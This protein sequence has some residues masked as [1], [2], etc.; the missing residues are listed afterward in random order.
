NWLLFDFGRRDAVGDAARAR[1][2]AAN[3]GFN[4]AHQRVVFNVT[5][6][7]YALIDSRQRIAVAAAEVAAAKAVE[8]AVVDRNAHGLATNVE[9]LQ[10]RRQALESAFGYESSLSHESDALVTLAEAVG[11]LP[12]TKFGIAEPADDV[13]SG[14]MEDTVDQAID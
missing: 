11:I 7:Y 8:D 10:A 9:L 12:T 1:A 4:A 2:L 5:R 14:E 3:L 13:P 6:A